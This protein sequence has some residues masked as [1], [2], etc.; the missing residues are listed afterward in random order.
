MNMNMYPRQ[1]TRDTGQL[2]YS[3]S[4]MLYIMGEVSNKWIG[5]DGFEVKRENERFTK[6]P[7]RDF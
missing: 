5:K 6:L 7:I 4:F 3:I 1:F 2:D